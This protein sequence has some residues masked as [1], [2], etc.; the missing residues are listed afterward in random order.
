MLLFSVIVAGSF[1]LGSIIANDVSPGALTALRFLIAFFVTGLVAY[2]KDGFHQTDFKASWRYFLLGGV[3][4]TY[5]VLMFQALKTA[6]PISTSAVFTLTP[7]LSAVAGYFLLKQLINTRISIALF[8][9]AAIRKMTGQKNSPSLSLIA[10]LQSE[11][12]KRK[13]RKEYKRGI[14][15]VHNNELFVKSSGAQGSNILSSLKDANCYIE[16]A[17]YIEKISKGEKVKVIPFALSSEY[18]E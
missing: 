11:I 1:S 7:L 12:K 10:K 17:E 5:F 6:P 13:G 16:L 3:F 2:K 18:Y 8:V 9:G 4:I 15:T 14:L